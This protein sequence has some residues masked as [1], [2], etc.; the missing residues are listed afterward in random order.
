VRFRVNQKDRF[1][2]LDASEVEKVGIRAQ[3]Q[4]AI[5]VC[6]Q[7]VIAVHDGQRVWQQQLLQF[8]AVVGE[9]LAVYRSVS[10]FHSFNLRLLNARMTI[11]EQDG[12]NAIALHNLWLEEIRA[13]NHNEPLENR[14]FCIASS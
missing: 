6:R 9:Q 14:T 4:D 2:L 8:V 5:G 1:L 10:H 12:H 7:D 11:L 13:K 3:Q